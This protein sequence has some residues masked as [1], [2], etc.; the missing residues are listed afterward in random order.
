MG[1]IT[2][3]N[4]YNGLICAPY[5]IRLKNAGHWELELNC[6]LTFLLKLDDMNSTI[7]L[8]RRELCLDQ[9]GLGIAAV[10]FWHL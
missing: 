5:L 10:P 3:L 9:I 2:L 8:R 4:L 6:Q 7:F 1:F